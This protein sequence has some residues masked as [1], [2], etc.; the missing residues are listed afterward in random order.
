MTLIPQLENLVSKIGIDAVPQKRR[1]ILQPLIDYIRS[2][3]SSGLAIRLNF[4]CTHNSR[5]SHLSQVWAQAMAHHCGVGNVFTYSGG[6]ESTALFPMV[7]ETLK[8]MGFQLE[9]IAATE[10]PIYAIKHA[11]N[12]PPVIGFSKKWDN[13][14][15]PKSDFAAILTCMQADEACPIIAGAEVRIPVTY[16][17]PKVFDETPQQ[18]EIYAERSLQIAAEMLYVFSEVEEQ[19]LNN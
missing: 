4:I 9:T 16:E 2:K 8:S 7:A 11:E 13:Q 18:A 5:R 15:N 14:F 1:D 17:D 10:N 3:A 12:E 6:T 19:L